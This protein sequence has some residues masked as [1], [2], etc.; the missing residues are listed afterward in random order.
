MQTA[1]DA[2]LTLKNEQIVSGSIK[3][4]IV[5][6][7]DS[8][9]HFTEENRFYNKYGFVV[10]RGIGGD[11]SKYMRMR[12]SADVTQLEPKLCIMLI[13]CNNFWPMEDEKDP[14]TGD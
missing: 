1:G 11:M 2:N 12:F 13:G 3:A 9:T 6:A 10:N 14:D 8:S 5:C 4:D 7:G